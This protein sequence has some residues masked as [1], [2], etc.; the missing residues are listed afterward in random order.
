MEYKAT[1]INLIPPLAF[2]LLHK[3]TLGAHYSN[4]WNRER[5]NGQIF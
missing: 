1:F 2:I 5:I 3:Y 4:N